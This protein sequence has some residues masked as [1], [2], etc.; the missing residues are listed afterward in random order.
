MNR[1]ALVLSLL[2]AS[3]LLGACASSGGG[4]APPPAPETKLYRIG[5]PD[6]LSITILPDPAIARQVVVRPD[7]M[8]SI[9]LV[10]DIPVAGRSTEEV[11]QDIQQ[12]IARFK[13][14]AVV[15]V[16]LESS[17]STEITMLGE[18]GSQ[19]TFPLTKETRLIEALGTV[20]G[21]SN[22]GAKD[23]VRII[24]LIDGKTHIMIADYNAML[25]GDLSTNYLLQGGDVI[26]VPPTGFAAA[27]YAMQSVLFP[28]QQ[29]LGFGT[30]VTTKVMGGP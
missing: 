29:L 17:L 18:V 7:G 9:D 21:I 20:G 16:A 13:R 15:T 8:I 23:E 10:G 28:I 30:S 26:V 5:P 24:R 2:L 4:L 25:A 14:D 12:R 3:S 1:S 11:A 27:G 19:R 6:R 22:N